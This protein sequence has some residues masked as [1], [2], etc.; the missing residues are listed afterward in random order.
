MSVDS[1]VKLLWS[2]VGLGCLWIVILGY[3]RF[4]AGVIELKTREIELVGEKLKFEISNKPLDNLV[5]ESNTKHGAKPR[6]ES[7]TGNSTSKE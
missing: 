7:V 4:R 3:K 5:G 6:V 2:G 1:V